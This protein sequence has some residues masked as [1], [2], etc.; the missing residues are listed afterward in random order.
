[1]SQDLT[2]KQVEVLDWLVRHVKARG[3]FPTIQETGK[4]FAILANR[5]VTAHLDALE[6]KGY[7]ERLPGLRGRRILRTSTGNRLAFV[8]IGEERES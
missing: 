1:M 8:E 3:Y 6:R 5:G 2:R 7:L 4:A